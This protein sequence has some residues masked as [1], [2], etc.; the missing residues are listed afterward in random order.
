MAI[1]IAYVFIMLQVLLIIGGLYYDLKNLPVDLL[2][3]SKLH[4]LSMTLDNI[5]P[6]TIFFGLI[7]FLMLN[8]FCLGALTLGII[9]AQKGNLHG[10]HIMICSTVFMLINTIINIDWFNY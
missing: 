5:N 8:L 4:A 1:N 3:E 10:R 6:Q 9:Q 7:S 2:I